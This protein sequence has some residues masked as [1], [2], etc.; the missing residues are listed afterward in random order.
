MSD[1]ASHPTSEQAPTASAR[2]E[3]KRTI[4]VGQI[5]GAILLILVVVFIIENT[6]KVKIRIIAGPK[7]EAPVY[8]A[9]LIAAVVGALIAALLRYRRRRHRRRS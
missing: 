2:P 6:T 7:V 5:L 9:I 1:D 3:P 4:S 8:V